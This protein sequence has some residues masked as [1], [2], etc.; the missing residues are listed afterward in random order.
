MN[1]KW[2]LEQV[3]DARGDVSVEPR[4]QIVENERLIRKI[5]LA[6]FI[7]LVVFPLLESINPLFNHL[8]TVAWGGLPLA[9]DLL[10]KILVRKELKEFFSVLFEA[11]QIL[12]IY[13]DFYEVILQEI[14]RFS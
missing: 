8:L 3:I 5:I 13:N 12:C 10:S 6:K 14:E 11:Q 1:T 2:W 7:V 4:V 9:T